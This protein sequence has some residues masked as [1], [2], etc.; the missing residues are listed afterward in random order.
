MRL[1]AVAY[2]AMCS[3][4][5]AL[6]LETENDLLIEVERSKILKER[7]GSSKMVHEM[8][9]KYLEEAHTVGD[10]LHC[11]DEHILVNLDYHGPELLYFNNLPTEYWM[12]QYPNVI[13]K[14]KST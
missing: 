12:K 9:A 6:V 14:W 7:R 8:I 1:F 5:F 2:K 3:Q 10:R 4:G 11:E 13:E